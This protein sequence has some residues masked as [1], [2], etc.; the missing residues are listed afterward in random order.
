[1]L[2]KIIDAGGTPYYVGGYVRDKI[3]G[4]DPKDIDIEVYGLSMSQLKEALK[5][6]N[7]KLVGEF[8]G[9]LH[10][11][12]T[13]ISLPRK[14][15]NT[16]KSHKDFEVSFDP[17]MDPKE[18]CRRR[19]FT[20]NAI[21]IQAFRVHTAG[22]AGPLCIDYFGGQ[23]DIE[24]KIIRHVDEK[25]FVEDPLRALRAV[26]FAV[27]FGMAID[28]ITAALCKEMD[29]SE[30]AQERIWEELRKFLVKGKYFVDYAIQAL[31][32]TDMWRV[33][34]EL[35]DMLDTP[36]D[37]KWHP[38][39]NVLI[40]TFMALQYA[41]DNFE[42]KDDDHKFKIMLAILLHDIGKPY[43]TVEDE[44]GK[45]SSKGHAKAGADLARDFIKRYTSEAELIEE[46]PPMIYDHMFQFGGEYGDSAIRRLSTRVKSI[47]DLIM[48]ID[49]DSSGKMHEQ[50]QELKQRAENLDV[51]DKQLKRLVEY[52]D[53]G[54]DI[55]P[56]EL[57]GKIINDL[58]Q[59][60][61]DGKFTTKEEG[62]RHCLENLIGF[63]NA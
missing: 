50:L 11:G 49:A 36:Q 7:P 46:I 18:A 2:Q 57:R 16:G 21:M 15:T 22:Y 32:D 26:Q 48:V 45:I 55:N 30:L 9:V 52:R 27:R 10:V 14:D 4:L 61:L 51:L 17:F 62:V 20:M 40:H 5:D 34:P 43:T 13:D 63:R 6:F 38:E 37:P 56:P 24:Y 23:S 60:Q 58:Y 33:F 8:F 54:V 35:F 25:H 53:L 42:F 19:D 39:G 29:L 28:P 59:D 12:G 1:M 3:L 44:D 47:D 41:A 31:D